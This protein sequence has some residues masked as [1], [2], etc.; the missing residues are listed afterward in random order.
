MKRVFYIECSGGIWRDIADR[1]RDQA[2]WQPVLWTASHGDAQQIQH[3]FPETIFIAGTDAALGIP[4]PTATW[5]LPAL[6]APLLKALASDESIVLHMMDRMDPSCGSGFSHDAR[7]RHYHRLL[8]YWLGAMDALKPDLIVFSIAPHIVFDYLVLAIA[9]HLGIPTLMFERIGLPGWVYPIADFESGSAKLRGYLANPSSQPAPMQKA[10][11]EWLDASTR[12]QAAVPANYQKKLERY[13]L[14]NSQQMPS[15]LRS[16]VHE[17]K[18]AVVL[19][20]KNGIRPAQNTY[21]R[22]QK[23]PHG[24]PGP[25]EALRSRLTGILKKRQL[26][27]NHD[28]IAVAPISGENYV[29]LG[30]HYQPERATVPMGGAFGDQ[31]LIVDMLSACLPPGWK[32]YVKEHPWQLQAFGRGEVQR[33]HEFYASVAARPN[34]VFIR[35]DVST[36]MLVRGA[37]A[38]A[39]V[40]GSIGWDALC[41]GIPVILFGAAWY[42]D[43]QGAYPIL[44]AND[45]HKT[46]KNIES[47]AI[48]SPENIKAFCSALA[49]VCVPGTL[50]PELEQ[51]GTL[52]PEEA[53]RQM[54]AALIAFSC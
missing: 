19:F 37:R 4:E 53:A 40:T 12:G 41:S 54:S 24:R 26:M 15:L 1:C 36:A 2:Q 27:L 48:P 20:K 34:V 38:V 30:L 39:T 3:Q 22:S 9:R 23:F 44:T 47:G 32:L 18:R 31:T 5:S 29:L 42:R 33:S 25:Y 45:L 21:L 52:N 10:F 35:R 46:F 17:L 16:V 14:G 11:R 7:R 43:C 13:K 8:R 6:D 51:I 49:N 50:E 28:A